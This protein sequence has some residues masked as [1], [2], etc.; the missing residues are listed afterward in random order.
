MLWLKIGRSAKIE[1]WAQK[2]YQAISP[3]PEPQ[4]LQTGLHFIQNHRI[5]SRNLWNFKKKYDLG[6]LAPRNYIWAIGSR[7]RIKS[8]I[9]WLPIFSISNFS[10]H[11]IPNWKFINVHYCLDLGS[12]IFLLIVH[13]LNE[14]L[15]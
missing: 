9:T 7:R 15:F 13:F 14:I 1:T 2:M 3:E 6:G 8:I 12:I 4:L 5:N 10:T 11:K